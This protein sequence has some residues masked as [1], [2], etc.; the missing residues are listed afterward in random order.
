MSLLNGG[1]LWGAQMSGDAPQVAADAETFV[2]FGE[3]N[4][5]NPLGVQDAQIGSIIRACIDRI[6]SRATGVKFEGTDGQKETMVNKPNR[7]VAARNWYQQLFAELLLTGNAF[8]WRSKRGWE[9]GMSSETHYDDEAAVWDVRVDHKGNQVPFE[10]GSGNLIHFKLGYAMGCEPHKVP[11][12]LDELGQALELHEESR[13]M[14][15]DYVINGHVLAGTFQTRAEVVDL[16]VIDAMVSDMQQALERNSGRRWGTL[17][18]PPYLGYE[19]VGRVAPPD[20]TAMEMAIREIARVFAVPVEL[21]GLG[22][23]RS[24]HSNVDSHLLTDAV[25]PLVDAVAAGWSEG[26]HTEIKVKPLSLYRVTLGA[27]ARLLMSVAQSGVYTPDECREI[28]GLLPMTPAQKKEMM[29]GMMQTAGAPK[30]GGQAGPGGGAPQGGRNKPGD[31]SRPPKQ[32]AS[33]NA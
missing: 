22:V 27:S 5:R 4:K 33:G 19:P 13:A 30:R 26:L 11:S 15:L 29:E 20:P 28:V 21:L 14:L 7:H 2:G 25:I 6:C 1:A 9:I 31:G 24:D 17:A 10:I 12:P 16:D 18:V 3:I 8:V 23:E 32:T